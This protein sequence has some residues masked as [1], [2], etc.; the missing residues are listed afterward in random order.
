MAKNKRT[1]PRR[2]PATLADVNKAKAQAIDE[3]INLVWS[4]FFMVLNDKEGYTVEDMKRVWKHCED[5][6]DGIAQGYVT[7]RDLRE[8]LHEENGMVIK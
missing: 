1:N 3:A 4:I 7:V 8:T 5:L 6:S 2:R